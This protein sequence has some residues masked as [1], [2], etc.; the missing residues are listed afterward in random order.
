MNR[1]KA[2]RHR[3]SD[4]EKQATENHNKTTKLCL[5]FVQASISGVSS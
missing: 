5:L 1:L 3:N 2:K 4:T